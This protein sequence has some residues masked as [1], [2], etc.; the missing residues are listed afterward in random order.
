MNT[1]NLFGKR[2]LVN[3]KDGVYEVNPKVWIKN[4]CFLAQKLGIAML[5][6]VCYNFFEVKIWQ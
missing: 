1:S 5:S 4:Y 3:K 2:M 6:F